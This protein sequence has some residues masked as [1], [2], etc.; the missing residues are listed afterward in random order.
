[1]FR[2]GARE[3]CVR[4]RTD[5]RSV[6]SNIYVRLEVFTAVTMKNDV[7]WDVASCSY[8]VNRRF[9]RTNHLHLQGREI[10]AQGT[11]KNR[12]VQQTVATCTRCFLAHGFLYT[13]DGGNTFLRNVGSNNIYMAPHLRILH[14]SA[15]YNISSGVQ[16]HVLQCVM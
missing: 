12:G 4:A 15:I 8:C 10:R 7:L 9:G 2:F 13:E 11:G 14:S 3:M 1:M 5:G 16:C 6:N